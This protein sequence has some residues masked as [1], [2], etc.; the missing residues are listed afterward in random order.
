MRWS[1]LAVLNCITVRQSSSGALGY[2]RVSISIAL[3]AIQHAAS[4]PRVTVRFPLNLLKAKKSSIATSSAMSTAR[5]MANAA[6]S[7]W[8][9]AFRWCSGFF[10]VPSDAPEHKLKGILR[11]DTVSHSLCEPLLCWNCARFGHIPKHGTSCSF[12]HQ[13]NIGLRFVGPGLTMRN[14]LHRRLVSSMALSLLKM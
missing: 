7:L 1:W 13:L 14:K 3:F 9:A 6:A 8:S 11:R 5:W 10:Q 12:V 4:W 2:R